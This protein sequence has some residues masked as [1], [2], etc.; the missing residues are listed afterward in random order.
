MTVVAEMQ[1]RARL[2]RLG[3]TSET[4]AIVFRG[5]DL[6]RE[7]Q[8]FEQSGW[9]L[10]EAAGSRY[11]ENGGNL[12]DALK[13]SE[14]EHQRWLEIWSNENDFVQAHGAFGQEIR[15]DFGLDRTLISTSTDRTI[16]DRFGG[17]I[18]QADVPD[19]MLIRQTLPGAGE[20][21]FLIRHGSSLFKQIQ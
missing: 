15:R 17:S 14:A 10:S 9:I 19:S 1:R 12:E 21:E 8:L 20:S 13:F 4:G 11:L 3:W 2:N 7:R 16:V 5:T 18:F 6:Y